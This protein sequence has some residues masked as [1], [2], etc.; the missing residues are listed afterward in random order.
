MCENK[1]ILETDI[2]FNSVNP[3][4]YLTNSEKTMKEYTIEIIQHHLKENNFNVVLTTKK[5]AIGKST[6]YNLIK[7]NLLKTE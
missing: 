4:S 2:T 3:I 6:I 7:D 5:L 1:T